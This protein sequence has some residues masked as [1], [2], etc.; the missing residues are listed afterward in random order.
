LNRHPALGSVI[1]L[2]LAASVALSSGCN[3]RWLRQAAG[4]VGEEAAYAALRSALVAAKVQS[5]DNFVDAVRMVVDRKDYA[6]GAAAFA[7][8]LN[9]H[10]ARVAQKYTADQLIA[11]M[12]LAEPGVR[13]ASPRVG[14]GLRSFCDYMGRH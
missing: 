1:M 13:K 11:L 7:V 5:A 8:A 14:D 10:N 4:V 2:G 6:G 9:L 12:R 3:S